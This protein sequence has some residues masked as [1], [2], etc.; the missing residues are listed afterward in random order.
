MNWKP[1]ISHK[2]HFSAPTLIGGDLKIDLGNGSNTFTFNG[3]SGSTIGGKLTYSGGTGA[4][5]ISISGQNT[6][7]ATIKTGGGN[8]TVA[9]APDATLGSLDLDFGKIPGTKTWTPP[10]V[11]SFPLKL[12]NFP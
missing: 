2:T 10:T 6:F 8:D 12:K 7:K 5:T 4:D 9:F 3:A 11:I 1:A